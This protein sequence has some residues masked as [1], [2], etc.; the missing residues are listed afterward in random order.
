M[1]HESIEKL[2]LNVLDLLRDPKNTINCQR[3]LA[4]NRQINPNRSTKLSDLLQEN[5]HLDLDKMLE[6]AVNTLECDKTLFSDSANEKAQKEHTRYFLSPIEYSKLLDAYGKEAR[7]TDWVTLR[8][9]KDK[10]PVIRGYK[11]EN[12]LVIGDESKDFVIFSEQSN[13]EKTLRT[14]VAN[15]KLYK[16]TS[17]GNCRE[18]ERFLVVAD[19]KYLNFNQINLNRETV[20]TTALKNKR[21]DIAALLLSAGATLSHSLNNLETVEPTEY[22]AECKEHAVRLE[23]MARDLNDA[24]LNLLLPSPQVIVH[25]L[26]NEGNQ[27]ATVQSATQAQSITQSKTVPSNKV[28]IT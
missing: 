11:R 22:Q 13:F 8:A 10:L 7:T 15:A 1:K 2:A 24:S 27:G 9:I 18:V 20:L 26:G 28:K 14:Q 6:T 23:R 3:T 5:T 21:A 4:P 19:Y 12:G 16:A 25:M 17:E